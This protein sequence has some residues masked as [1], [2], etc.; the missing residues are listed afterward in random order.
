MEVKIKFLPIISQVSNKLRE[1]LVRHNS[2]R[3][4]QTKNTN[5]GKN[6]RNKSIRKPMFKSKSMNKKQRKKK[7]SFQNPSHHK[8][9]RM[10]HISQPSTKQE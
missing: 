2:S 4:N 1:T 10:E 9:Q 3:S 6:K 8:C 7:F 5:M